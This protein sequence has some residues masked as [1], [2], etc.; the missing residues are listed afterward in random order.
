MIHRIKF[1]VA[2]LPFFAKQN[3]HI[4]WPHFSS[5]AV[6]TAHTHTST[7]YVQLLYE[8]KNSNFEI[9]FT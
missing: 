8:L 6:L 1:S 9:K 2:F 3:I 5:A 4:E 7:L